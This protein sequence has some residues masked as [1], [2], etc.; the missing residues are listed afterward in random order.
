MMLRNLAH[1]PLR[2]AF[3]MLGLALGTAILIPSLFTSGTMEELID[4]TYFMAD[5]QDATVSFTEKRAQNVLFQMAQLPGVLRA[6]PYRELPVRIRN[7]S[8]ERRVIISGRARDADL[9]RIID[10]NLRPVVLPDPARHTVLSGWT[11]S[12]GQTP[13]APLQVSVG[14]QGSPLPMRHVVPAVTN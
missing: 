3:T 14:S 5:R 7:G 9:S 10:I 8:I 4:L 1:H 2:A 6:E 12:A 13:L 11:T